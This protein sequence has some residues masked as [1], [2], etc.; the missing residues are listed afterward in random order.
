MT[1]AELD[2]TGTLWTIPA[3]RYKT[4]VV[5]TVPLSTHARRILADAAAYGVASGYAFP[6]PQSVVQAAMLGAK[7]AD[8]KPLDR[9]SLSR[10]VLRKLG[11]ASRSIT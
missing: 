2:H 7:D 9:H 10:A 3:A 4:G 8:D 11:D 6:S 5:Q 1:K